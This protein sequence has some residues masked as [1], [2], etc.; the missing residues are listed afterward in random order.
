MGESLHIDALG[1]LRITVNG[2][3]VVR[4]TAQKAGALLVYLAYTGQ[5]HARE[6]LAELL[7]HDHAPEQAYGSLRMALT[8]LR[9]YVP[10]HLETS[11]LAIGLV[12]GTYRLDAAELIATVDDFRKSRGYI[13][14]SLV[15][16]MNDALTLY[17]GLLLRDFFGGSP[18]FETW[19]YTAREQARTAFCDGTLFLAE[20][21]EQMGSYDEALNSLRRAM[22]F[23]P[24]NEPLNNQIMLMLSH[25]GGAREALEQY[26]AYRSRLAADLDLMRF[27]P[28]MRFL[29]N[30]PSDFSK[31]L[32]SP[33]A[34]VSN[35]S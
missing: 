27:S 24:L 32:F 26:Q 2:N 33:K 12:P 16:R 21:S 19:L 15:R 9:R 6:Y 8:V 4:F 20:H 30:L 28:N 18:E 17:Q 7:W 31:Q 14:S 13:T 25:Q 23:D 5:P 35:A 22:T 1:A 34:P 3:T 29:S 11:R 10:D